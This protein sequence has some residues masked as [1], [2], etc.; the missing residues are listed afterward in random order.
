MGERQFRTRILPVR[1]GFEW[2]DEE[3]ESGDTFRE[4]RFLS[5]VS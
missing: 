2:E 5:S 1:G 4:L 3:E